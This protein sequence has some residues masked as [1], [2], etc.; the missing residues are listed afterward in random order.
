MSETNELIEEAE[1][2]VRYKKKKAARPLFQ[3]I[4]ERPHQIPDTWLARIANEYGFDRFEHIKK[5]GAFRCYKA[6]KL[7]EWIDYRELARENEDYKFDIPC[8]RVMR[9]TKV[10]KRLFKSMKK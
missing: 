8:K 7:V 10:G 3:I 1:K 5:F 2:K 4:G 6:G 9:Y